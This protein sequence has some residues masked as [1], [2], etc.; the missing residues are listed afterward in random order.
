MSK[1]SPDLLLESFARYQLRAA[2]PSV[3]VLAGPDEGDG[4]R[5]RL[6]SRARQLGLGSQV[7]FTGALYDQAKWSAYRDA[8]L[9]VLPSQ[10]ENFG[11]TAA[12]AVA[13]GTPVLLTDRC[14]VA[15]LIDKRAGLVVP[16]DRSALTAGLEK[17]LNDSVFLRQLQSGC[18][19]TAR[20]FG[21][22]E[23]LDETE[24]LYATL[25]GEAANSRST[26]VKRA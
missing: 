3:L 7:L 23:P 8:D 24:T 13:C 16:H 15:S 17:L 22:A 14:G 5:Q 19:E 25:V 1:K 18:A 9:F 12:E 20:Q 26:A 2:Q 11:N 6:E 21:W 4:Y 10:N